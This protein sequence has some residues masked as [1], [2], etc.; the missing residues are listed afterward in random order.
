MYKLSK[1][2]R[3]SLIGIHPILGFAVEMA[4]QRTKQDFTILSTGGVRTKKQ[5]RVLVDRGASK[6]MKS[7]HLTGN[8]VDLVAWE[9]NKPSWNPSLYTEI[10]KAMKSV[11]KQY[12]LQIEWG[13]DWVKFVDMP[14]WQTNKKVRKNYDIR[15]FNNKL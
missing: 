12:N 8:A 9:N 4:I 11:I 1:R 5:Q 10:A 15:K 3:R 7:N 14:H 6:T 2:S 13:G